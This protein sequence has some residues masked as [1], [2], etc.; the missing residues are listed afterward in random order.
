MGEALGLAMSG[1]AKKI[2]AIDLRTVRME[3][4]QHEHFTN[5]PQLCQARH[6][7]FLVSIGIGVLT[8]GSTILGFGIALGKL[9][10]KGT[11]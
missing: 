3:A 11:P 6:Q 2:E 4:Q 1:I 8:V 5:L 10:H 9:L 7:R